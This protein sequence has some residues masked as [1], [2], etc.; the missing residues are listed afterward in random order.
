[1]HQIKTIT[2]LKLQLKEVKESK[3]EP[4]IHVVRTEVIV[5]ENVAEYLETIKSLETVLDART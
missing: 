2:Q 4:E 3:L 5:Q 1:M